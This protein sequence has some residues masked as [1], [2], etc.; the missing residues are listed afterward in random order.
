MRRR[1]NA[2]LRFGFEHEDGFR[3][4]HLTRDLHHLFVGYSFG[5]G[6]DGKWIAAERAIG[7]HVEL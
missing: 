4:I 3:E 1:R 2:F 6:K 7:E 5:F